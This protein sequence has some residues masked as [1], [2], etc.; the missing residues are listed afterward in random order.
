MIEDRLRAVTE[1][2]RDMTVDAS[3]GTG[4]TATLIA[5]VTN[6]FLEKRDLAPE[7]VLLL[8]FTEKAAGE[9]KARLMEGWELLLAACRS[10]PSVEA[11]RERMAAWNPLVVVPRD[12][13]GSL[14]SHRLRAAE[15]ADGLNRLW[16]TTFHAFCAGILHAFPAEA[17]VDPLF[18]VLPEG[19][20]AD[21]WERGFANFLRAEFGQA[22]VDPRWEHAL[23]RAGS[24]GAVFAMIRRLAL[25]QR[26]L[27]LEKALD[28]GSEEDLLAF[29]EEEH[30]APVAW[31]EDFVAGIA[32]P[33]H[34][35]TPVF[36]R[37]RTVLAAAWRAVQEGDLGRAAAIA[38]VGAAAFAFRA[39]RARS[40]KAFPL[41]PGFTLREARDLI[42]AFFRDLGEF[43]EGDRAARFLVDRARAAL[44]AYEEAKGS[45][46]DFMDLLLRASALLRGNPRVADRL[47]RRFRY[48]LVDEFQDTDPLQADVLRS[49]S[50]DVLP[51]RFFVVGDPKQSIYAFRRADIQIYNRFRRDLASGGGVEIALARN[52]RSRP[53]LLAAVNG[54]FAAVLEKEEDFSPGYAPVLPHRDDRGPAAAVTLYVLDAAVPE[55]LFLCG[56]VQRLAGTVAVGGRPGTPERTASFRDVAV[57]YRS[58]TGGGVL[59]GYREAFAKA[60]V[61]YVV[62]SRRG[63][64]TR[65]EVQDLRIVLS[66]VDEP[67][68][69]SARYAALKTV[70]FGIDDEEILTL[71]AGGAGTPRVRD[72][73]GVL[74][75]LTGRRGRASLPEFLA[76]LYGET[77][78]LFVAARLPE[79]ER[80][81]QNLVK[82]Q[83]MAR[84]F[85]WKGEGS[86]KAYAAELR[87]RAGED[88]EESEFP[89]FEEGEDAVRVS[90]IH[91]SKGLEFP[92]V[93][94][95][96]MSRGGRKPVEGLRVDRVRNLAAVIFPGFRTCSALRPMALQGRVV[97]FERWEAEKEAAEERRIFYVA[98][99]RARDRL[100]FVTG[101]TGR[102]SPIRDALLAG[103]SRARED[104]PARCTVT[105]LPGTRLVFPEGGEIL[106]VAV[107]APLPVACPAPPGS[108]DLEHARAWA[109]PPSAPPAPVPEPVSLAELHEESEGRLF[110][111]KV[112]RFLEAYP[113]VTEPWPPPGANPPVAWGPDE[114]DR[115]D[116]IRVRI[117]ASLFYREL[118]GGLFVGAEVPLF[119][120]RVGWAEHDRADLIVRMPRREGAA[121]GGD[122]AYWI[123]DY[124]SGERGLEE[125]KDDVRKVRDYMHIVAGAW[126]APVRGFIWYV[127]L[128]ETIEVT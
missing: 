87:R 45:G 118:L 33:G 117:A 28:F 91:A 41:P 29:L 14:E 86:L 121:G 71:L 108:P 12:D 46:L 128:D 43:P 59:S 24:Q 30:A 109:A 20:S 42:R 90:T 58:D 21:A 39:D 85:E 125:E 31:F 98:A 103:L 94:L 104:G 15:M 27:L 72:A 114:G 76:E 84:V 10:L 107:A 19:A 3:A 5:R 93:I 120:F 16:V 36:E 124:K 115:W 49:L 66:A 74:A 62:P 69:L 77:G 96:N 1:F 26:D 7:N 79:G 101:G 48:I 56:L 60:G 127:E 40:R 116:R 122:A 52:F 37:A 105:G 18:E 22:A 57:L 82:A 89:A 23:S 111:E 67:A 6:L 65:Q 119:R 110:G 73:L 81:V 13:D 112:H 100:C 32:D 68:N 4:K 54:L 51:G 17:G 47:S 63:F 97:R 99:T 55:P 80:I 34:E 75:R 61:P 70:F 78:V 53:D 123:V 50:R 88:R 38:P 92:V 64:Y 106:R 126:R 8:T 25:L 95:A 35:M 2:D 44:S 11:V 83:E 9:M 113:P 102:G